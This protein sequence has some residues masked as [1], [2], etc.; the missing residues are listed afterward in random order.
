MATARKSAVWLAT[1]T[2]PN[3]NMPR[4]NEELDQFAGNRGRVERLRK[5]KRK[6]FM[7]L[8][9]VSLKLF[10]I[11]KKSYTTVVLGAIYAKHRVWNT[12]P[13]ENCQSRV[14]IQS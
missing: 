6:A 4:Q 2:R 13:S 5:K 10:S 14:A 12:D 7:Q 9:Q 8:Q 11:Y 1:L 3:F